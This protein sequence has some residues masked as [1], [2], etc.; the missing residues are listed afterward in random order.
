MTPLGHPPHPTPIAQ[1]TLK[2]TG[3]GVQIQLRQIGPGMVQQ[4]QSACS[5]CRGAG[6]TMSEKDKC[7]VRILGGRGCAWRGSRLVG[8]RVR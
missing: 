4:I 6:K 8:A 7:K 3:R 1:P 2:T 5:S